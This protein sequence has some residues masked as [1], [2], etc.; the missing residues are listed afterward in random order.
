[1]P[2]SGKIVKRLILRWKLRTFLSIWISFEGLF[3]FWKL[4][5]WGGLG[6]DFWFWDLNRSSSFQ[7]YLCSTHIR[8]GVVL[9]WFLLAAISTCRN[10]VF[11]L[12]V[13]R[14]TF[15]YFLRLL[16]QIE[17]LRSGSPPKLKFR[18][19][20]LRKLVFQDFQSFQSAL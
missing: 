13:P 6:F 20:K 9:R 12:F 18:A 2:A 10:F 5:C 16:L 8:W 19:F 15:L 4:K 1:M 7:A 3:Q 14:A 11:W 17:N